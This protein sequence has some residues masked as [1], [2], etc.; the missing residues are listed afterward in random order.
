MTERQ[1]VSGE[2]FP[3][4]EMSAL[5]PSSREAL[6]L[7]IFGRDA[8]ARGIPARQLEEIENWADVFVGGHAGLVGVVDAV[9]IIK[10]REF[11][12]SFLQRM[13]LPLPSDG[14]LDVLL[15]EIVWFHE[16]PLAED[17]RRRVID[18]GSGR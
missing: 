6:A 4:A 2:L 7:Q 1:S 12:K 9:A 18:D 15:A 5:V 17:I 16:L 11:F 3:A 10:V 8:S 13:S 14:F